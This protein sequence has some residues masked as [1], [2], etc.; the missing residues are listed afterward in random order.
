MT[1]RFKFLALLL[2]LVAVSALAGPVSARPR[3]HHRHHHHHH[4]HGK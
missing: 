3:H 2:G 4:H 1:F